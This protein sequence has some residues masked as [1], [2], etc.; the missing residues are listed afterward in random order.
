MFNSLDKSGAISPEDLRRTRTVPVEVYQTP[1][2][3]L[4]LSP[5]TLNSLK[6]HGFQRVGQILEMT[7]DELKEIRNFGV[8]SLDEL[9]EKLQTI[10]YGLNE[11]GDDQLSEVSEDGAA[12]PPVEEEVASNG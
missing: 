3:R 4:E 12:E 6:N 8:K 11:G 1:I 9:K 5:R 10:G 7:D 2:E